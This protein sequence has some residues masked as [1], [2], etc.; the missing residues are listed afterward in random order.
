MNTTTKVQCIIRKNSEQWYVPVPASI[1]QTMGFTKSEAVEWTVTDENHLVLSRCLVETVV[2]E[3]VDL[4]VKKVQL[5]LSDRLVRLMKRACA[6]ARADPRLRPKNPGKSHGGA[7]IT[8]SH[9]PDM[10]VR[11]HPTG[12]DGRSSVVLP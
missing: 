4:G 1:T 3:L 2:P 11:A 8:H 6:V 10:S 9:Q 5:V 12:R 7:G